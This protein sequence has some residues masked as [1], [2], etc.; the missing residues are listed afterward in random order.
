MKLLMI[1]DVMGKPGRQAVAALLPA[2]KD[3]LAIE[4]VIAN[5]ENLAAGRGITEKTA[6]VMFDAG[7]DVITSGN[8]VRVRAPDSWR[9]AGSR[10]L[11]RAQG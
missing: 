5:G 9:A 2:L 8:H 1:G 6:Q 11:D 3:E 4:F 7:V 10:P